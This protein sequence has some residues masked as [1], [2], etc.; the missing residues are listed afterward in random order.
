MD[1][2]IFQKRRMVALLAIVL[3]GLTWIGCSSTLKEK[4]EETVKGEWK[5]SGKYY[6][7]DDVLIP[8]ALE[9]KQNKSFIYETPRFKTGVMFFSK[10]WL[11]AESLVNFFTYNMEKDNWK[12]LNSF[13][14]KESVLNFSKPEKNCTIKI[15]E[16]WNGMTE[17]EVRV[18]PFGEEPK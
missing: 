16:A 18:G 6:H 10:W 2:N 15:S 9:Y 8:G 1:K 7:F 5:G 17:V 4:R 11:D 12:L 3:L 13:R 14:G